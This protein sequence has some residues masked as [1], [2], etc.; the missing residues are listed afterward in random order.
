MK[1]ESKT[2]DA[3]ARFPVVGIGASAGGIEA[4]KAFFSALPASPGAVFIVVVHLAPEHRSELAAILGQRTP[5]PVEEVT[6]TVPVKKDHVYVISPDRQLQLT[7]KE[8]SA[9]PF[10]Q[11]RGHRAPVD[12]LFRSLADQPG[13][14]FAV[15]LSGGGSD[16]AVGVGRVKER[17]GFILVQE[18]AEAAF[19]SMP[20]SAIATGMADVVLPVDALA[21][22]LVELLEGNVQSADEPL[23]EPD[24]DDA[25][26][27]AALGRIL[28][29]LH[30]RTGHDFSQ[31]KRTTVLRRIGRR[32]QIHRLRRLYDYLRLLNENPEEAQSLF[33]EMLISVTNF[34]R[35]PEA[36]QALAQQVIPEL[37]AHSDADTT[38]RMWVP[39]CATG[40]EAYSLAILLLEA[41][42]QRG[43]GAPIQIFASDMDEA[44]LAV[45]REG[46]YPVA[47]GEDLSD[48]RLD[49]FFV[50]DDD[51]YLVS[52][53]L[54]DCVLFASH[55]LLRDPPFSRIDL[56][57]CRNLLIYLDRELQEKVFGILRYALRPGGYLFVG[58]SENAE[59]EY[60]R[61]LDRRHHIY[62][63][64]EIGGAP[65][66]LPE[67]LAPAHHGPLHRVHRPQS[68]EPRVANALSAHRALLEQLGPPSILVDDQRSALY[69]SET[70]GRYL[71][72]PGGPLP[73]DITALVRPELQAEL[74]AGLFSALEKGAPR[75][76]VFLPVQF[77]GKA[78]SVAVLVQPRQGNDDAERLA[79]VMF[80][81]GGEVVDGDDHGPEA[82]ATAELVDQLK[83]ELRAT[84]MRL[85]TAQEEFEA[86]NEELR[87]ANEE[88]Q[89]MNEEYRSVA[90]ELETS[91]E[92]LQSTNEELQT[93][94]SELKYKL[95]E[96][97][98]AH[99]DLENLMAASDIPTL[100][101]DRELS[102]RRF[103]PKA[104]DLFSIRSSDL[105]RPIYE[106]SRS[107]DYPSLEDDAKAVLRDLTP[108]EREVSGADGCWYLARLR[109]YRT[110]D[111]RIDGVV[112]S[113]VDF[114]AQKHAEQITRQGHHYFE[115]IVDTISHPLLVLTPD[116]RVDS[117]NQAF[118]ATFHVDPDGTQGKL[119]Y[120]L[121]NGQWDI[122]ELRRLLEEVL[123]GNDTFEGFRVS[124]S[125]EQ[126]GTR[127]MLLNASRLDALQRILL[128][129]DDITEHER[130]A[131]VLREADRQ[132]NR[133]L[134]QLGHELRNPLAAISN[135]VDALL[136]TELPS[137]SVREAIGRIERQVRKQL[138]L[139]DDV[140]NISRINRGQIDV[141]R[142]PMD[143][144]DSIHDAVDQVHESI[145]QR[146]LRLDL[147]LPEQPLAVSGDA[148]RL[149]QILSNLLCNAVQY[150]D[151]G[152]AVTLSA[153]TAEDRVR[154]HVRD[155][156]VGIA[157]DDLPKV[158]EPF[159][160]LSASKARHL[161]GLG[162]GLPLARELAE[163]HGG[164][165]EA[166]SDG[167]GHGSEFVLEL[168][169]EADQAVPAP[170]T[171][172]PGT[173]TEI[174]VRRILLV[175]DDAAVGDAL[176]I[177][178]E[179]LGQ[180]VRH[181]T[182][183][184]D[185]LAAVPDFEPE[186]V[187]LDLNLPDISGQE[188]ARRLR[189]SHG[190]ERFRLVALSGYPPDDGDPA[191]PALFERHLV[192]PATMDALKSLLLEDAAR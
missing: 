160:R 13:P 153:E 25:E 105:D 85:H 181:A 118:Y 123:P 87:A 83:N 74:S 166:R 59:G 135:T 94:N 128:G 120:E 179:Q 11:Q 17:S 46:R 22:R 80:L 43:A 146:G 188:V 89:S 137:E 148:E 49:R 93:V 187:L 53:E 136:M 124:H 2:P 41:A 84:Q 144:R 38:L 106:L 157:P 42:E 34:F 129:I 183:G 108:V 102:I 23:P 67:M 113:F 56:I 73:R 159:S 162:L 177:L 9:V 15:I 167:P 117:A 191:E 39:G 18:P 140:L 69:L 95:Q 103:T 26:Q 127:V 32:M 169:R 110:E 16:G 19:D 64:R 96:V 81:E 122:P 61:S 21:R 174:P 27:R 184:R 121:G 151:D 133:F 109:P 57:S 115:S 156:G 28:D 82:E 12:L 6:G 45:A 35:D 24:P 47:I 180:T 72:P 86:T 175:E 165:L 70:A 142:K 78:R 58:I 182:T 149:T 40:E 66:L 172:T 186:L 154:V 125:F 141:Q 101:L 155:S 54:R 3:T 4:L 50:R 114:T 60:F 37:L 77:N 62:Q 51:H 52:R 150:S 145:S 152:G 55:S 164:S 170:Q 111:H 192:K 185:A 190:A 92:E 76:S 65:P 99:S 161:G 104:A 33:K 173:Q 20:R 31:Y 68:E 36:W 30:R 138:R 189:E 131:E 7:G 97:S 112:I 14:S 147:A 158:F 1:S 29:Q 91:K 75:Q 178:L 10:E 48:A 163:L 119:I 98:R 134:A 8:L 63:A 116:L 90:E 130:A 168:P 143:L 126:I 107:V 88:L 44:A 71:Q 5:M 139:V 176:R 132:K 79:L 100:F 171:R